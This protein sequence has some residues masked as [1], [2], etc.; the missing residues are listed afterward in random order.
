[1]SHISCCATVFQTGSSELALM[2]GNLQAH[3]WNCQQDGPQLITICR[4]LHFLLQ[5]KSNQ[6]R[7]RL[8][9]CSWTERTFFLSCST[10]TDWSKSY[11]VIKAIT[12]SMIMIAKHS[13]HMLVCQRPL[14]KIHIAQR[15]RRLFRMSSITHWH[16]A[17]CNSHF[18]FEGS[19][20]LN[21]EEFS[22]EGRIC[23]NRPM[24]ISILMVL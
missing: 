19:W 1:M 5:W 13:M 18:G 16:W 23:W 12:E 24:I 20:G 21:R 2:A 14:E 17:I 7:M 11:Q 10:W 3:I 9:C 8:I 22:F 6:S 4:V 15:R